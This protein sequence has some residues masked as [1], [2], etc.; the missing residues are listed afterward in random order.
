MGLKRDGSVSSQCPMSPWL[1]LRG[2]PSQPQ[3]LH[4]LMPLFNIPK[5]KSHCFGGELE[6]ENMRLPSDH[7]IFVLLITSIIQVLNKLGTES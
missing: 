4:L 1:K 2:A 7:S 3:P 6:K 5:A